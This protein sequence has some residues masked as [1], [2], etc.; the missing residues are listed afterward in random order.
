[1]TSLIIIT[2]VRFL[3]SK[4][5]IQLVNEEFHDLGYQT[6]SF[7]LHSLR[8]VGQL[9]IRNY[10]D[11]GQMSLKLPAM[12]DQNPPHTFDKIV[13]KLITAKNALKA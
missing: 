5:K 13:E 4:N 1:M 11:M 2:A 12:F 6:G 9:K 7:S 10:R 3:K 8:N